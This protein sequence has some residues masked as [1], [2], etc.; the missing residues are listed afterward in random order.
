M[1][2][3]V[4]DVWARREAQRVLAWA[5][6]PKHW[7]RPGKDSR[8]PGD[9]RHF[10]AHFNAYRAVFTISESPQG[11]FRHL[12]ISVLSENYPNVFAAYTIAALFGFTGWDEKSIDL[13][14]GWMARV[15]TEEHCIV[16]GQAYEKV[17]ASA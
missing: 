6:D 5:L 9:D 15:S 1:R 12:S 3:L 4:I 10:V 14:P 8:I 16:L 17:E 2:P 11:V 13:P 7:Y